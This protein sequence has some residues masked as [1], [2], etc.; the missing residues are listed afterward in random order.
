M[1]MF[2]DRANLWAQREAKSQQTADE[3]F[4][5]RP[6]RAPA[7]DSAG[8]ERCKPLTLAAL[9][10]AA[11]LS[12]TFTASIALRGVASSTT[13]DGAEPRLRR[14]ARPVRPASPL[15]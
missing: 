12:A 8:V 5:G 10:A 2:D 6:R 1:A 7:L 13:D 14:L 3:L 4:Y 15:T 9:I 11:I